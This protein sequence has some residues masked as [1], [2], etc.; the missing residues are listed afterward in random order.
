MMWVMNRG[1]IASRVRP[2]RRT[3]VVAVV[4]AALFGGACTDEAELV[5][6]PWALAHAK[7]AGRTLRLHV[8]QGCLTTKGVATRFTRFDHLR[9]DEGEQQ[10]IIAALSN[11][12]EDK[13]VFCIGPHP[14]DV[15]YQLKEPVGS[16]KLVHAPVSPEWP[17]QQ[18]ISMRDAPLDASP[19]PRLP[20]PPA[21]TTPRSPKPTTLP[22]GEPI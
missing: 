13:D 1:P 7:R 5:S 12:V 20:T 4:L 17:K 16:R 11:R 6:T 22:N 21:H 14:R 10:I 19:P 15:T 2:V 9:V 8:L 3:V 18:S